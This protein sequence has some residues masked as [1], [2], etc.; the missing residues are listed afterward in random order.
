MPL[1][2]DSDLPY[3]ALERKARA[4]RATCIQLAHDGRE[5]HLNG[6]LSSVDLLVALY[7][8]WLRINPQNPR[9]PHRDR[10]IFSKG[11]ACTSLYA[12]LADR[13]LIPAEWLLRYAQ[14]DSPLPSHPCIHA[15]PL[16]ECSAGSLGHGLG[17]ATGHAYALRLA[18]NTA[19][20]V[21]LLGDGECNEGSIWEA[22]TF[23]AANRQENLLAIVDYNR[24]QSVGFTDD[25]SGSTSLEEKFRAFGW[26]ARTIDGHDYGQ[27][28]GALQAFPYAAGKPSALIARTVAGRGVDFMENQILWHYR[29]PSVEDL[30]R[31]LQQLNARPI[32]SR[33]AVAA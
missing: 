19:R 31:A 14:D 16:L 23:A 4:I 27:I 2:S 30:T 24:T 18:K 15:L 13:G 10:L 29:V 7:N 17:V 21:A 11:H 28:I 22:A 8:S 33:E 26:A 6:A 32:Y 9:D 1:T 5:G 3:A 20:I 25:L 12:V